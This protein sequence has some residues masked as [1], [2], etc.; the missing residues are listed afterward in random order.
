MNTAP[1]KN[2][3]EQGDQLFAQVLSIIEEKEALNS[4]ILWRLIQKM[5]SQLIGKK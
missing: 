3:G 4:I 1:E 5:M 2:V